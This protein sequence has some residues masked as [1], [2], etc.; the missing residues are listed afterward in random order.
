MT[1][2]NSSIQHSVENEIPCCMLFGDFGSE[3]TV[4]RSRKMSILAYFGLLKL[5]LGIVFFYSIKCTRFLV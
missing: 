1:K 3:L 2:N 4:G 5:E